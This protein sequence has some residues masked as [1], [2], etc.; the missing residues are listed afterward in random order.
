MSLLYPHLFF[1]DDILLFTRTCEVEVDAILD[2]LISY[3]IASGQTINMRKSKVSFSRNVINLQN[4]LQSKLNFKILNEDEKY[5]GL[6]TYIGRSMKVVF[7]I[8]QDWSGK[9]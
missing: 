7:Q 9:R 5:L 6:P 2:V 3:K 1:A 4:M 8:I